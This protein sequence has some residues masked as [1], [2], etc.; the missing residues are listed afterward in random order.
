MSK[1]VGRPVLDDASL[2]ARA[3]A[4]LHANDTGDLVTAAPRLYPH[5]WSW[6]AAFISMGL[7]HLDIDRA[8]R[9]LG[10]LLSAQW[11]NGML[12]HIVFSDAPGYF[13][14]PDWWNTEICPD[15]P[16]KPRTSGI[17]QPPAHAIALHRILEIA[18]HSAGRRGSAGQGCAGRQG[19]SAR[20][21]AEEFARE[22]WPRLHAWHRWLA[23]QRDPDAT[24]LLAVVHGWESGMDNSP[25][26]DA[27]YRAVRPG[28]D[29]PPYIRRD[30]ALVAD[31]GERP[32][33]EEYDRYLWLIE[34][35]RRA[36]YDAA[37]VFRT[38][39]FLVADVFTTAIFAVANDALAEIGE[40]LDQPPDLLAE[41][42]SWSARSRAAVA[43]SC[44]PADPLT[45]GLA[46]DR[47]LRTGPWLAEP[48]VA[49]FAPLLCGGLPTADDHRLLSMFAGADWAGHP[50]FVAAVPPSTSPGSAHFD[51]RRYWRGPQ[52]PVMVWLFGWA[53]NR[54]GHVEQAASLRAE[55]LRLTGDGRFGEYYEPFT[56]Q[57][58]GSLDQSWTAAVVLDWLA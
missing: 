57:P 38:S 16:G 19:S 37:E 4:V 33:D 53:L 35:M 56:G 7:A 46:R 6:D 29:L 2:A 15:A 54:R 42:R 41:L 47:D 51:S 43:A 58:L 13:P 10:T 9:E 1:S 36:R 3:A 18:D 55:G 32:S 20:R 34:E 48:T 30:L 49:G 39:S 44:D 31:T 25:R 5:M 23:E 40:R 45:T 27:P 17:C 22:A 21:A 28:P 52:W 26:W 14:G 8:I 50:E 24:G 11:R 12:P